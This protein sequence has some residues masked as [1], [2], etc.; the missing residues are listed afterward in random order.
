[1]G[2][3]VVFGFISALLFGLAAP[4]SKMLLEGLTP[5]QLAGLLYTGAAIGLLPKVISEKG[6]S[7]VLR[8]N[9]DNKKLLAGAVLLGGVAGP[10]VLL[11]GLKIAEASSVSM[12]LNLELVF[13]ALL[14]HFVFRDYLGKLG[15]L[16][17]LGAVFAAGLLSWEGGM[18]GIRAGLLVA[19]ACLF[20]GLDNHFTALIDEISPTTNTFFKG[21][22][23]GP[24]NL[25]IGFTAG[26]FVGE[27]S[28]IGYSL[29]L[30]IFS[31]GVS[32]AL[33]ISSAQG[34]GAT[35]AQ[36]IF[37]S[38]PFFGVGGSLLFLNESLSFLQYGAAGLLIIALIPLLIDNHLHSHFH[39]T[40]THQHLHGHGEG[41]HNHS[42][43]NIYL[44]GWIPHVHEHKHENTEHRHP[45]L[46]DIHH[47]H[48][49]KDSS[50]DEG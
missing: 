25:L 34:I 31:Y 37:A 24:I 36:V 27:P 35:R 29:I 14:G 38:A 46:P 41:H 49:H 32:I 28:V 43:D 33:Y 11:F 8:M 40:T 19:T 20:W 22:F 50:V 16:G 30:G 3:S 7:K 39:E 44:P 47:R 2:I 5:F 6:F 48:R 12:W 9:R 42:H 10:V 4:F 45:H 21:L 15:W 13:T 23:A 1:M 18:V 26:S 17:I